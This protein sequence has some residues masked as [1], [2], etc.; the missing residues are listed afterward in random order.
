M[1]NISTYHALSLANFPQQ[2][3]LTKLLVQLLK[4]PLKLIVWIFYT[5]LSL[6]DLVH[7]PKRWFKLAQFLII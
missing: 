1:N 7:L 6:L 3:Q 4:I 2:L 5:F